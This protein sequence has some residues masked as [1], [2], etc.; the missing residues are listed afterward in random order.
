MRKKY[1]T[2][3]AKE[4]GERLGQAKKHAINTACKHKPDCSAIQTWRTEIQYDSSS[5]LTAN[6]V[7]TDPLQVPK[8]KLWETTVAE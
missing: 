2:A 1:P 6:R 5:V 7:Y 8:I 4:A 3:D